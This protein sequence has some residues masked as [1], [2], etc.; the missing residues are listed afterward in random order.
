[1]MTTKFIIDAYN[2]YDPSDKASAR[3][4]FKFQQ[5]DWAIKEYP[6]E[7]GELMR[8]LRIEEPDDANKNFYLM[9]TFEQ[10]REYIAQQRRRNIGEFQ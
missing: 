6:Y 9:D 5:C 10:A 3:Y 2:K 7:N 4:V 8:P 1:M